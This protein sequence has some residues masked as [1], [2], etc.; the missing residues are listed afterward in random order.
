MMTFD[1]NRIAYDETILKHFVSATLTLAVYQ[2]FLTWE[3]ESRRIWNLRM[4]YMKF[5]LIANRYLPIIT[6]IIFTA[7]A[8]TPYTPRSCRSVVFVF[9][10]SVFSNIFIS[11]VILTAR[12]YILWIDNRTLRLILLLTLISLSLVSIIVLAIAP[13]LNGNVSDDPGIMPIAECINVRPLTWLPLIL[14]LS[15][16]FV[17]MILMLPK[18]LVLASW[19]REAQP[20]RALARALIS[21]GMFYYA[22][23]I[24][25]TILNVILLFQSP[26]RAIALGLV[27]LDCV[28]HSVVIMHL[29]MH[30]QQF[31]RFHGVRLCIS[32]STQE[33]TS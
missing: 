23:S 5:V 13:N 24:S 20:Y 1:R 21:D 15:G 17:F 28:L 8:F 4:S 26:Q 6:S 32:S 22:Y 3:Y 12:L 33:Q 2:Y 10:F 31:T 27:C 29:S 14:F 18:L 7:V 19:D 9:E 16:E 25:I 30:L 11:A